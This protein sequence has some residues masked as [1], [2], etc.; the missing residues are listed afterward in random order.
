M[1]H[2]DFTARHLLTD[3]FPYNIFAWSMQCKQQWH[4]WQCKSESPIHQ[5]KA[6]HACMYLSSGHEMISSGWQWHYIYLVHLQGL[7]IFSKSL[8][9]EPFFSK[10]LLSEP[11]FSEPLLSEPFFS[12]SLFFEPF[13]SE[14][15]FFEPFFSESLLFC[16]L[17][18]LQ[19][20]TL[21]THL[22]LYYMGFTTQRQ[23]NSVIDGGLHT[24]CI[25]HRKTVIPSVTY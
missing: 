22:S 24:L 18:R 25:L 21:I 6:I 3:I 12:E 5:K 15:L 20:G 1:V 13:L 17:I 8:L 2:S 10:S 19:N 14:S 4:I 16:L 9:S 11:F 7:H 23:R